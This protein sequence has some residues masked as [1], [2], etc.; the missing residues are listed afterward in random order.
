[1]PNSSN[2][3][4]LEKLRESTSPVLPYASPPRK[5][6]FARLVRPRYTAGVVCMVSA[7]LLT[8]AA[9]AVNPDMATLSGQILSGVP[10]WVPVALCPVLVVLA[11]AWL[12][13][14]AVPPGRHPIRGER[15]IQAQLLFY[16][17]VGLFY[18]S[19]VKYAFSHAEL[20]VDG[21]ALLIGFI[22][23]GMTLVALV[24]RES[25]DAPMPPRPL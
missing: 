11:A 12:Y 1:M 5:P 19:S 20:I 25:G 2:S 22:G 24:P 7:M 13:K 9:L 6:E 15:V 16:A 10:P 4:A 23:A 3:N 17:A 14:S 18:L 21:I 8:T